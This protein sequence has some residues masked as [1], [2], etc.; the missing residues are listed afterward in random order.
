MAHSSD[1]IEF[2][3]RKGNISSTQTIEKAHLTISA[4]KLH[5]AK[6]DSC[7]GFCIESD[8]TNNPTK[9]PSVD[10]SPA[11][12][13]DPSLDPTS[14]PTEEPTTKPSFDPT[15]SLEIKSDSANASNNDNQSSHEPA[16]WIEGAGLIITTVLFFS[17][18][19][20]FEFC[21]NKKEKEDNQIVA[22]IKY[23]VVLALFFNLL[24]I[25]CMFIIPF[26][27]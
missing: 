26:S 15:Y 19:Y 16:L 3:Y 24:G 11:P 12:T 18:L 14:F 7:I 2:E 8:P 13:K 17:T 20:F 4:A 21:C 27:K 9:Y 5:C 25:L 1:A 22:L 10:P 23:P 6:L